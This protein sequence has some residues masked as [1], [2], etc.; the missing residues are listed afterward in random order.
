MLLRCACVLLV[1]CR[2]QRMA[3]TKRGGDHKIESQRCRF[4]T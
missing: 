4:E 3:C 1:M 2:W